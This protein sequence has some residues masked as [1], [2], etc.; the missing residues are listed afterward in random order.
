MTKIKEGGST[1]KIMVALDGSKFAEAVIEPVA[2][3]AADA[4][5]EVFLVRVVEPARVHATWV[6][7]PEYYEEV[8]RN[9][10]A[11]PGVH[12][13]Q[14]EYTAGK[15]TP[16]EDYEQALEATVSTAR[17]YLSHVADRFSP[18]HAEPV[19]LLGDDVSEQLATFARDHRV[20]LIAMAS[21]G[22][23]GLARL[24]MGNH[25]TNILRRKVA[26]VMIV[27]PDGLH[28]DNR[29]ASEQEQEATLT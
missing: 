2:Q 22:R 28:E 10:Y 8:I 17:D 1:M 6:G 25:A 4:T 24:L 12:L 3:L 18:A 16:V 14:M 20:D 13:H 21:H 27:R 9:E 29:P 7:N 5:A 15:P 26:P 19:V 23:T 11:M